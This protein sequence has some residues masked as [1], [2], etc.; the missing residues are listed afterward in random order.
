MFRAPALAAS[1]L[2]TA[3]LL[4]SL[5]T[6]GAAQT[7]AS[8][9][10]TVSSSS[11]GAP[12]QGARVQ[13]VGAGQTRT[14]QTAKDGAF[15]VSG[16][17]PGTYTLSTSAL[18]F[19]TTAS[20]PFPLAPGEHIDLAVVLEPITSTDIT[21]L[22]RVT[23]RGQA[24]LNTSSA[25]SVTLSNNAF[26][27]SGNLQVQQQLDQ[28]PGITVEHYNNGAPGAV[29]TFT[30][31]GAGGFGAGPDGG[32]N[33][34][35]E[36]LVLQDG[37][38]IRNGQY[39]DADASAFTPAIYSRVE[40][41]KGVGGTS[42]FGAD[43]VG[44]TVN[45]VTRDPL[46]T[47]GGQLLAG[48]GGFN[49][50][51][52]NLSETNTIGRLGYVLDLHR[53]GTEGAIPPEFLAAYGFGRRAIAHPTQAMNLKSG[54]LKLRYDASPATYVVLTATDESDWRDQLGIIG[55]PLGFTDRATQLPAFFGFPGS[56]VWAIQPKYALDVHT[57]LGGG[58][59]TLRSYS[60]WLERVVDGLH[61]PRCCFETRSLDHL[62]GQLVSWTRQAGDHAIT[63]AIGGNGDNFMFAGG[64]GLPANVTF[65]Q[66]PVTA[67]GN[68]LERT[69]LI[70]DDYHVSS[71]FEA[72]LAGYFSNYD[73]LRVKRFDP[74]LAIVDKA[75]QDTVLRASIGTGFAPPRLSD[76]FQP[77]DLSSANQVFSAIPCPPGDPDDPT[78]AATSGNPDLKAE[79]AVGYDFGYEH[80]FA[81]RGRV[82][83]DLYR[84][85]MTNHIF[86]GAF[87]APPGL[88]FDDGTP[89]VA[90]VRPVNLARA[91]YTG[92]ELSGTVPVAANFD[93]H[94]DYN[95]QAAYPLDVDVTTQ[96]QLENVVN[97][98]QFL[99]VP[100]HKY[101]WSV[102]YMNQH[103]ANGFFGGYFYAQNNPYNLPSFWVY[104]AGL[105]LPVHD[106]T[107]HITWNNI[108]NKNAGLFAT[109]RGG[110]PYPGFSGPYS[111]T[112]YNVFPHQLMFTYDHRWGSL[113]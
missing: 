9:S 98:R 34:G 73:T 41:V 108:F 68:Q 66:L 52:W 12:I 89:V 75:S 30:I 62:T 46:K 90:I 22:G 57:T 70:R 11:S 107:L 37:E 20:P 104:R 60:Q 1:G 27:N 51:D 10:G 50:S 71:K 25:A 8:I 95:T 5:R 45:L 40:V 26:V 17:T 94:A 54:L 91:V 39:G 24:T 109:F 2:L 63:L 7:A 6:P 42:L 16:L 99:G 23:V 56:F 43:T 47:E 21:T 31:R 67:Q 88:R 15:R 44:G 81:Q 28:L 101:A 82:S 86:N 35:Y 69:Y 113:K 85:N 59:L 106:D 33:T 18:H 105:N 29:A 72:T 49:T 83:L 112:A 92:I 14:V 76:L 100:L 93:V 77:L 36:I 58:S 97:N 84:T 64:G 38:P 78:C 80:T 48:F 32:S 111:T 4:L 79:A 102:D 3:A 19:Q 74:R 61:E 65:A 87:P 53:Y 96:R 13:V 55:D 103:R 110:V